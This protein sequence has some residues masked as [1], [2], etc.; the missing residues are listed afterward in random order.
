MMGDFK[1]IEPF[2]RLPVKEKIDAH[3]YPSPD[4][5][6]EMFRKNG[7]DKH[8][9]AFCT[10]LDVCRAVKEAGG[11]ALFVGGCVRDTFLKKIPK[12]FDIEVYGI[13]AKSIGRI[14]TACCGEGKVSEVGKAFGILK[15]MLG[16]GMDIDVSLPRTDSKVKEGHT[17]FDVKTDPHMSIQEAAKRR[18][19]T[20]NALA[21]DPLTGEV[22][23]FYGGIEDLQNR[24]LRVTDEK[25][26]QDDPLRVMR[27]LQF[28]ARFGMVIDHKTQWIMRKTALHL[29][30]LPPMRLLEEWRKLLT[31]AEKP[32][33]GL[34]AGMTLG[35][36]HLIHPEFPP[37]KETPQEPE[38]HPEGDVWIHTLMA[39]D[40]AAKI[41][42]RE[43]LDEQE[44]FAVIVAALCHDIGKPSTT[45][46][47]DGR[48]RSL[49]H[50]KAGE[51][52]TRN[53]LKKLGLEGS[54][55]DKIPKLVA[56]H[57]APSLLYIEEHIKGN[58]ISDGAI[59]KLAARI[60]PATIK[61][62]VLIA[63]A[64]HL[65]RGPYIDPEDPCQLIIPNTY[66]PREWL[67][68]R[69]RIL[70]VEESK[71]T[72]IIRGK[73]LIAFGYTPGE[74]FGNIICSANGL[75]D[76]G[77]TREQIFAEIYGLS[78]QEAAEKLASL[79]DEKGVEA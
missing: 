36:F 67:L 74:L 7:L 33:L 20:I 24:R 65:G 45:E 35:V 48:I 28:I 56:H 22:F 27:G 43:G 12:D 9:Q 49:G 71:P 52:P 64:D 13:S 38:W 46:F 18:D 37:M 5:F 79:I 29:K 25:L 62:L 78:L 59:R 60:H 4:D 55:Q 40:E 30:E 8:E 16:S 39:V 57:L 61:E 58:P 23:D 70:G 75:R 69:A 14:V 2:S 34:M 53:F 10:A 47:K 15:I 50:E 63:E 72:D 66:P 41:A 1:K 17:G 32:S 44:A 11:R 21:A 31:R 3:R 6:F 77:Y 73:D 54:L 42:K 51:E 19:F 26:F 76:Q 68:E